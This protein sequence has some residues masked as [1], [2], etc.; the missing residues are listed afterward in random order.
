MTSP[1]PHSE[2]GQVS[3]AQAAQDALRDW[4][5]V[6]DNGALQFTPLP[7]AEPAK[8]PPEWLNSL[9]KW[10][11]SAFEPIGEAL[12]VSWPVLQWILI[13]LAV[14]L[15]LYI[16]WRLVIEPLIDFRAPRAAEAEPEWTPGREAA[17]ALLEDADRL[18]A[19]GRYGEATRLLLQ[20]S[21]HHIAAAR[22]EWLLPASTAREIASLPMLPERA[23]QAFGAIS[24]RVE[25]SLFALRDLDDADWRAA[26]QA[27]ADFALERFAPQAGAA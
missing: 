4:Q 17:V 3:G 13:G 10:L 12:G 1:T 22:P 9:A 19:A 15:A 23:R 2:P 25:R 26:R 7:P 27:Y 14:L 5:A 6:R 24:Q 11:R 20:R 8:P 16:L 21:V 18:A